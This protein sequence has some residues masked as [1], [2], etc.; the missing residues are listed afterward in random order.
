VGKYPPPAT[1]TTRRKA[2]FCCLQHPIP[3]GFPDDMKPLSWLA[4]IDAPKIL[5]INSTMPL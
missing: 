5:N 3:A 4:D 1:L 2:G